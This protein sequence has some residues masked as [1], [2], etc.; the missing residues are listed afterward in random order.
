MV[1]ASVG[2]VDNGLLRA[3]VVEPHPNAGVFRSLR[4]QPPA[5]EEIDK[6]WRGR[7][8]QGIPSA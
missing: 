2:L 1:V 4:A 3:D 7:A 6:A 5:G 8:H